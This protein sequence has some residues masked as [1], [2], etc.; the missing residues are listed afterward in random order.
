[1]VRNVLERVK[2]AAPFLYTDNDPYLALVDGSL[3]WIVDMYTISDRYPYSQPA[4][5]SRINDRSGLPESFNYIRNSV[6]TVVN[7]YDGT[8][9]FYI[10]D[11]EDPLINSYSM[12]F[13]KLFSDK[14]QMSPSLRDHLRYPEDLF[15]IQSDMYRVY[16]MTNQ[17]SFM[18]MKI[19]GQ[20]QMTPQQPLVLQ[21]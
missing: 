16:H 4:N 20:Y 18:R 19:H 9:V 3:F 7:A 15:T 8:M 21:G 12:I 11:S 5:T 1:M 17:K 13:P 14:S 6:K 10:E 2:K